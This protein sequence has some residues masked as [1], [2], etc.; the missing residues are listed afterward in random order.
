M[1]GRCVIEEVVLIS[2]YRVLD[3]FQDLI[4]ATGHSLREMYTHI[5]AALC[6][7]SRVPDCLRLMV[8]VSILSFLTYAMRNG[9]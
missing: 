9:I 1:P 6:V 8:T 7:C 5:H 2:L 4:K 3:F